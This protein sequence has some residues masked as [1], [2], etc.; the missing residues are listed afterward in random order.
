MVQHAHDE[1]RIGNAAGDTPERTCIVTRAK[2]SP[3]TLIRFVA[4]PEGQIV[5][6]LA[7]RLPGRGVWVNATRADVETATR[8]GAFARAL[9]RKVVAPAGLAGMVEA[10]LVRRL[11]EALSLAN[12]AGV[13]VAGY[14]RVEA[15]IAKGDVHVLIHAAEAAD[16][17][18]RKLDQKLV[19]QH[20]DACRELDLPPGAAP[21]VV[22]DLSNDELSLALGRPHVV[23]AALRSGGAAGNFIKAAERL[24]RY[25]NACGTASEPP[26]NQGSG[27]E[28]A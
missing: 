23:H 4:G 1:G 25:R 24:R 5:P 9:K 26:P 17:G 11:A 8:T 22:R 14:S 20:A 15:A 10:L 19:H 27:T 16:D 21:Q 6:D 7:G 2:G 28:Q 18:S 3:Q 13:V 12:K